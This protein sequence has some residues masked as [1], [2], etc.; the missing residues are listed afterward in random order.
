MSMRLTKDYRAAVVANL[1]RHR[2]SEPEQE[3]TR[4]E[5]ELATKVYLDVYPSNVRQLMEDLPPGFF[6]RI[7][8][9][10]V[11]FGQE[12]T[13][14]NLPA[15][16]LAAEKHRGYRVMFAQYEDTHQLF[17]VFQA[18][19][20]Q[21]TELTRLRKAAE[22]QAW[23]VLSSVSTLERLKSVWPEV[24]PFLPPTNPGSPTRALALPM[25][26]VNQLFNLQKEQ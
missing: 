16:R 15:A 14:L 10:R 6:E 3:Q 11:Q 18:F 22:A 12:V 7:T 25:A 8:K 5:L 13:E 4:A 26:S 9:L 21:K 23:A 24:V 20:A 19:E 1:L 17:H 2:F